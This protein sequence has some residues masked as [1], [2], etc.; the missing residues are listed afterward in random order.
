MAITYVNSQS[1]HSSGG[2]GPDVPTLTS[3]A[4]KTNISDSTPALVFNSADPDSD[5]ISYE[6]QVSKALFSVSKKFDIL[7]TGGGTILPSGQAIKATGQTI[8][9]LD[10]VL[11]SFSGMPSGGT[12]W[13]EIYA[14]TG[15]FGTTMIPTGSALATSETVD[16]TTIVNDYSVTTFKFSGA[17]RITLTDNTHYVVVVRQDGAGSNLGWMG[18]DRSGGNIGNR[19]Y[20]NGTS[21]AT[22][23]GDTAARFLILYADDYIVKAESASDPGFS[24][25]DPYSSGSSVTYT[26][27]SA[28][29]NNEMYAWKV[30]AKDPN[31]SNSWSDW[32]EH[33]LFG[34]QTS[35]PVAGFTVYNDTTEGSTI[36]FLGITDTSSNGPVSVSVDWGDGSSTTDDEPGSVITHAYASPGTYT[37]TLTATNAAGSDQEESVDLFTVVEY[38][39]AELVINSFNTVLSTSAQANI[40]VVTTGSSEEV[41]PVGAVWSTTSHSKPSWPFDPSSTASTLY[42]QYSTIN[43]RYRTGATFN[44]AI[45]GL[46]PETTYYVRPYALQG[47]RHIYGDEMSV[48]TT[49]P[50]AVLGTIHNSVSKEDSLDMVAR[51]NALGVTSITEAGFVASI[52][53]STNPGNQ[54]PASSAYDKVVTA[55]GT[56]PIGYFRNTLTGLDPETLYYVRAYT[57]DTNG[58]VYG[59]ERAYMTTGL[60]SAIEETT[61][62]TTGF[63]GIAGSTTTWASQ[64][65]IA[66]GDTITGLRMANSV[67]ASSGQMRYTIFGDNGSGAPNTGDVLYNS[68]DFIPVGG[69]GDMKTT[70]ISVTNGSKYHIATRPPAVAGTGNVFVQLQNPYTDPPLG[71]SLDYIRYNNGVQTGYAGAYTVEYGDNL[72]GIIYSAGRWNTLED[73]NDQNMPTILSGEQLSLV[74]TA[75]E[76]YYST[77][78]AETSPFPAH[79]FK[80]RAANDTEAIN[81]SW[82]G[83]GIDT[84]EI[85]LQVYNYATPGWETVDSVTPAAST[86]VILSGYVEGS[87]YYARGWTAV[88][89]ASGT[90]TLYTDYVSVS[91]GDPI[92][93]PPTIALNS[94][95]DSATVSSPVN[96]EFTGTSEGNEELTYEVS[97]IPPV[98]SYLDIPYNNGGITG[99]TGGQMRAQSFTADFTGSPDTVYCHIRKSGSPSDDAKLSIYSDNSGVP[100]S[101]IAD[102]D[103]TIPLVSTASSGQGTRCRFEFSGITLNSS[104]KYWLVWS[105]TGSPDDV[106]YLNVAGSTIEGGGEQ[107]YIWNGTAWA[108]T[109]LLSSIFYIYD[110]DE[111][112]LLSSIDSGFTNTE[113]GVDTDPFNSGDKIRFAFNPDADGAYKWRARAKAPGGS[114]IWGSWSDIRSFNLSSSGNPKIST[115][116]D[117]FNGTSWVS[118]TP[119]YFNGSSWS[120]ESIEVL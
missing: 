18:G 62:G 2:G 25:T 46:L 7:H 78:G 41:V 64:S 57:K 30:R 72:T 73:N 88:R 69:L 70:S 112:N 39:E 96:I 55:T 80:K 115:L 106:N 77:N 11:Y 44:F 113:D 56:F 108:A 8:D 37:V 24:G 114:D 17:N 9:K 94:P 75:D 92:A 60:D 13:A 6:V 36:S 67:Y 107:Q 84:E 68:E 40:S 117:D 35:A 61:Y 79:V 27:Q 43:T 118:L 26:V 97:I 99:S 38:E 19:S 90:A 111:S 21:W 48:T 45:A 15:T 58:Y 49:E 101:L 65:F 86:P 98:I 10:T 12:I 93:P 102:A 29:S 103:N 34:L 119:K 1:I 14:S 105:R 33:S 16:A 20:Y 87:S 116:V 32:S 66:K 71:S 100:G 52:A 23:S 50:E 5:T 91:F 4:N 104:T 28:L 63:T 110:G 74:S 81:M 31:G 83:M 42:E 82:V 109:S 47:S 22:Y 95:A 51:I 54:S 89:V 120:D 76:M 59:V 3:P 53:S 85:L